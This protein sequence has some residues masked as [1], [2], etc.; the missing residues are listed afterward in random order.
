MMEMLE[1]M[2][3]VEQAIENLPTGPIFVDNGK[4]GLP[5]RLRFIEVLKA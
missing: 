2:K 3:I 5:R 1:S 4:A